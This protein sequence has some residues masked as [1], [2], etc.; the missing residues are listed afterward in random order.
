MSEVR[1]SVSSVCGEQILTHDHLV[2]Q[3]STHISLINI[4]FKSECNEK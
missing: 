4:G 3:F 1:F 2:N